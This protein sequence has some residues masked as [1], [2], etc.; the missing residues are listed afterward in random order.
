[1]FSRIAARIVTGPA[2]FLV[3]AVID[4]LAFAVAF[5]RARARRRLRGL[6]K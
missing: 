1:V 4:V 2:A 6:V 3:A 5:L